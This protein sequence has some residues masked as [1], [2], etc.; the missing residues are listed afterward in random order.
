LQQYLGECGE[1]LGSVLKAGASA[2]EMDFEEVEKACA[3]FLVMYIEPF[4]D[5]W[6]EE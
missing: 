2:E 1:L 3:C 4:N 5:I 6:I